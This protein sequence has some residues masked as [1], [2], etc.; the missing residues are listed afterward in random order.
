MTYLTDAQIKNMVS[1]FLQWRLPEDFNPDGGI[2]FKSVFNENTS[3]PMKAEPVGTNLLTAKQA[4][5]M[6]RFMISDLGK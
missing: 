2:S 4:E 5:D 6:V 1:R 3:R